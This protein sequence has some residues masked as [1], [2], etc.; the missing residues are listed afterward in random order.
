VVEEGPP[1]EVLLRP[2]HPATRQLLKS[3]GKKVS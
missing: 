1:E 3:K 2:Q